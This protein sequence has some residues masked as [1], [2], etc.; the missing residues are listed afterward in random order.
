MKI[1][2]RVLSRA[3]SPCWAETDLLFSGWCLSSRLRTGGIEWPAPPSIPSHVSWVRSVLLASLTGLRWLY[4]SIEFRPHKASVFLPTHYVEAR[5]DLVCPLHALPFDMPVAL[6][7]TIPQ[8]Y[9]LRALP[10]SNMVR[11]EIT[12]NPLL[13]AVPH[14]SKLL[15]VPEPWKSVHLQG[16]GSSSFP[17]VRVSGLRHW[18]TIF[19]LLPWAAHASV[20]CCRWACSPS[21]FLFVCFVVCVTL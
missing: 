16:L 12:P 17:L 8:R 21:G 9:F 13:R 10:D 5:E 4:L 11:L 2:P 19:L 15:F 14:A 20:C 18:I 3:E 7:F 6:I 1:N